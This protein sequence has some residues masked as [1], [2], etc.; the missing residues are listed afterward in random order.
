MIS[1]RLIAAAVVIVGLAFVAGAR[2]DV[3]MET[4]T[5]GNPGNPM[6]TRYPSGDI[7]G[8]GAVDYVYEIGKYE[9]TAGQYTEFLNSVAAT[10]TYGLYFAY[11]S[12][13]WSQGCNIQRS[14]SSGN[15]TYSVAPD[16]AD[17]PV[18]Y[19][20]WGE[21]ARFANWMH[22][23]Q[24]AGVQD[25]STTEDGSYFLN[26]AM[27]VVELSTIA[28][29]PGATWVI[30]SEDEWYKAAYHKNDGVTG[31][32]WDYPTGTDEQPSNDLVA[33]DP[34]NN[35]N[36]YDGGDTIGGPYW[37]TEVGEF[38]NSQSPYDTFDM[39]GNVDE[40]N[41]SP[42]F[43]GL[44][45]VRGGSWAEDWGELRASFSKGIHSSSG[46]MTLGFRVAQVP[47]PSTVALLALGSLGILWKKKR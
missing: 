26:G 31:S 3:V 32:Y 13:V 35:A 24:P 17:R 6:D 5:V 47:E 36:F 25:L 37:R 15:Y 40:W 22:N 21:A 34:G 44:H 12:D 38:E 7:A 16:W 42:L 39:G 33:P 14:G 45:G 1:S 43:P 27:D 46:Y 18:N 29:K 11:M 19:V 8:F 2:A 10:D 4:V 41:E 23:G 20:S 30:P 28:R 9:V